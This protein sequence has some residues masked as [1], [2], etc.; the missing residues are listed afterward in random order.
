MS[1]ARPSSTILITGATGLVGRALVTRLHRLEPNRRIH[2]LTRD[3]SR[4]PFAE[5][6]VRAFAWRP[7]LGEMDPEALKNVGQIVHLAGETV[8]QRWGPKARERILASRLSTLALLQRECASRGMAPRLVSASAVGWYEQGDA[9][10]S[11]SDPPGHG[12]L[13]E[14]VQRWEEAAI[15]FGQLG[16]GEVRL[17][18]GLVLAPDGGVLKQLVPLYRWGLGAAL[19]PGTQWQSWIHREDLVSIIVK[20]LETPEWRGAFNAVSPNPV[21]QREFSQALARVLRRPHFLPPV[22][23]WAIRLRFGEAASA[24]LAS[25][26]IQSHKLIASG[27]DPAYPHLEGA[28]ASYWPSE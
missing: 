22:P 15:R 17:R 9:W 6:S 4:A 27:F 5:S 25:H 7:N 10:R 18:I 26:R 28:L 23:R 19:A 13:T 24:L 12:F 14:V 11:E 1:S 20:A 2:I 21:R 16:G 3:V 8:A